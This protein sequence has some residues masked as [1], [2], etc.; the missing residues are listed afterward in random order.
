MGFAQ[1]FRQFCGAGGLTAALKSDHH[2]E[3]GRLRGNGDAAR[4]FAHDAGDLFIDDGA[5]LL[6]GRDRIQHRVADGARLD[7]LD[8]VF[9][10]FVVD[11]GF[12]QRSADLAQG[13]LHVV[14]SELAAAAQVVENAFK[15]LFERIK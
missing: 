5:D 3:R 12:Q 15:P 9:D 7:L 13:Q 8:E 10:D 2:H 11:V 4:T 6:R 1:L 14:F